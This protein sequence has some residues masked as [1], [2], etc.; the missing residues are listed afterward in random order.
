MDLEKIGDTSIGGSGARQQNKDNRRAAA[1]RGRRGMGS[2]YERGSVWWVVYSVRGRRIRESS[3]SSN[4]ADATRLLKRRIFEVGNGQ[5]VGP[6][7]DRTTLA[8]LATMLENDYSANGRKSIR[9][10]RGAL[11]H[12]LGY[13]GDTTRA[14]DMTS[15]RITAYVAHRLVENASAATCNRECAALKR[16]FSLAVHAGRVARKPHI[17]MLQEANARSGFFERAE[18]EALIAQLPSYLRPVIQTAAITGWR[19]AS[20][21]LTRQRHHLDLDGE[22]LSL[23]PGETKNGEGRTFPLTPEL[24][25]VLSVQAQRTRAIELELECVIPWLFHHEDGSPILSFHTAWRA[26]CRRAGLVGR[27]P[28]DFRRTAVRNLERSGVPRSTA[29]KM[30]GH[31]TEA[32]YRRYAIVDAAMLKEGA[33]KLS[34]FRQN[35]QHTRKVIPLSTANTATK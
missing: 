23:D 13:F 6:D 16:A 34:A 31:K 22:W 15:D 17:S 24:H 5:P 10:V 2:I 25:E 7:V 19:V 27:I 28:H 12:L 30:V 21:I 32:I 35:E 3:G 33:T 1:A 18:V 4:R 11:K 20:E 29:M 8:E 26:A 9:R 14:V